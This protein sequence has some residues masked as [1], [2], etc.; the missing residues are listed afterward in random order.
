[1]M[2]QF[3][4]NKEGIIEPFFFFISNSLVGFVTLVLIVSSTIKRSSSNLL[5]SW[6]ANIIGTIFHELAHFIVGKILLAK[7]TNFSLIPHKIEEN[8]QKYYVLGHVGFSKL[9]WF[10]SLPVAMAPLSLLLIA[11]YIENNYW[12]L[13]EY[14]FWNFILFAYLLI[15]FILNAIPSRQDYKVAF[16]SFFGMLFWVTVITVSIIYFEEIQNLIILLLHKI[17]FYYKM[18]FN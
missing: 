8:G 13:V 2:N 17:D 7:P 9:N 10:N 5:T 6:I 3:L 11:Y 15:V 4:L 12:E 1:M 18:F 16:D 14:S